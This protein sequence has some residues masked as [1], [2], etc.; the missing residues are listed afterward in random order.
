MIARE[1]PSDYAVRSSVAEQGDRQTTSKVRPEI[2]ALRAVAV[3]LVV[4]YH[5]WPQVL[6]G[7][8][9]GVDIFFVISGF[10]ITGHL[11]RELSSTGRIRLGAFWARRA[12]RLL[13]ASLLVLLAS[14]VAVLIWIPQVFWDQFFHETIA[15]V[16][17]VEN[18]LLAAD[19]VDYLAAN[20]VASA[21]QHYWSLSVEEQFYLVW[22]LVILLGGGFAK[23]MKKRSG[24]AA[25]GA[26]LGF[27]SLASLAYCIAA[28]AVTPATAYFVTP[29]R[30]WEFGAGG[31]LALL[32]LWKVAWLD[33]ARQV[34]AWLGWAII[35]SVAVTYSPSTAF[36]GLAAL[37][38]VA[39]AI[40]VI[41]A[42]TPDKNWFLNWAVR[43]APVQWL[44]NVSYSLYLWHWP[45]IV[46]APFVLGYSQLALVQKSSI[47]LLSVGLAWLTKKW[48]ED[49]LRAFRPLTGRRSIWTF[50]AA[51]VAMILVA[52]PA[53]VGGIWIQAKTS[54]DDATRATLS[55]S[56]C[57]GAA[58]LDP[59]KRCATAKFAVISPD[60]ALAP[61]D[62]PD[63]YFTHPPCLAVGTNLPDCAFGD[64][65]SRIRV[66]LVGDSHAAQWEPALRKLALQHGWD[67]RLYLKTNCAF[68]EA[69][70][71]SA[72]SACAV[73]S[74]NVSKDLAL[75]RP[76]SLVI[77]SFFA[78]NLG[79]EVDKGEVT[80]DEAERGFKTAWQP[81]ISRGTS[82]LVI[83]DTP[84]MAQ[85]TTVCVSQHGDSSECDVPRSAALRRSDLQ[86]EA[87]RSDPG[88]FAIDMTNYFC[89]QATCSAVIGGVALHTDPYHITK[90]YSLTLAPYLLGELAPYLRSG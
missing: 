1:G 28:T 62:S 54:A 82:V 45:L 79:L 66:A 19:S 71:G 81:L 18:W 53:A 22:P 44:G 10:L 69:K 9:V 72:Y 84:H 3:L 49:P 64:P 13:P 57:F 17:Y 35:L 4:L 50:A 21:V 34:A 7:G 37:L 5:L 85:T 6:T 86:Y 32:P 74:R 68:S 8:F 2:Q 67:L 87:A 33:H 42:G 40:T 58:I 56:S 24:R 36:P 16:F 30:G 61:G 78:E 73:W 12:R 48:V 41:W 77:T 31:L 83:R 11:L 51:V 26:T 29:A 39:G 38:P 63:I 23:V 89:S 75:G 46:I 55:R 80:K 52:V 90:T 88:T 76:Y 43:K 25:I 14:G 15:S 65:S 70:R 60:P 47:L 20:N 27:V 59:E